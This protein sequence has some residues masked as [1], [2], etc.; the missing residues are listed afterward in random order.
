MALPVVPFSEPDYFRGWIDGDG[1][2]GITST[3]IPFVSLVTKSRNIKDAF[4]DFVFRET[5]TI[6]K[7]S[8]NKRDNIYNIC[9]TRESASTIASIMYYDGCVGIS[10]KIESSKLARSWARPVDMK[11]RAEQNRRWDDE[12]DQALLELPDDDAARILGRTLKS[13]QTRRW[14]LRPP[15]QSTSSQSST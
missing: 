9:V 7:P 8:R 12:C 11:N 4:C 15:A 1:S 10:R 2:V 13:V 14:R 3:G 5:G 6:F